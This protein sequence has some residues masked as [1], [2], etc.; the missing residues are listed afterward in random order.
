[1]QAVEHS[2]KQ[3][4]QQAG[5]IKQLQLAL[6]VSITIIVLLS[7]QLISINISKDQAKKKHTTK[8]E[9]V[10]PTVSKQA[11]EE[12]L[13]NLVKTYLSNFFS[14]QDEAID[15]LKTHTDTELFLHSIEP[16]LQKRRELKLNSLFTINDLYIESINS[17]QAKAISLGQENFP[18]GDY[19]SRNLTIEML[20]DTET[21]QIVAI[22][23]FQIN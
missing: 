17:N 21:L 3:W 23:V 7:Q 14:T 2:F 11:T 5:I 4:M 18:N 20:I 8:T 16:E 19:Q 10:Q 15:Y 9:E 22:P 13:H 1:M 12:D 6:C